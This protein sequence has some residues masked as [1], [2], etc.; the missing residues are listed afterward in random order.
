MPTTTNRGRAY[1]RRSLTIQWSSQRRSC[2]ASTSPLEGKWGWPRRSA[3]GSPIAPNYCGTSRTTGPLAAGGGGAA[4]CAAGSTFGAGLGGFP[5]GPY[6]NAITSTAA[7]TIVPKIPAIFCE[8]ISI[9]RRSPQSP[10]AEN[11]RYGE[12]G[13]AELNRPVP[14]CEHKI[15]H[16]S[17]PR[18]QCRRIPDFGPRRDLGHSQ[19][20]HNR[21]GVQPWLDLHHRR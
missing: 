5:I 21:Y 1:I 20:H 2:E 3:R 7:A 8:F 17:C 13:S 14:R 18:R 16:G 4:D 12:W 9:S 6:M 15:G 19:G 10:I 11:R